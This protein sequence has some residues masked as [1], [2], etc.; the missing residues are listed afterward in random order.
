[1]AKKKRPANLGYANGW[2]EKT[3]KI[4]EKCQKLEHKLFSENIG[5][6]LN[7]YSCPICSYYYVVDSS[8]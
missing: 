5:R 4:I 1:M 6:C 3:P 8:D 2:G 7:R